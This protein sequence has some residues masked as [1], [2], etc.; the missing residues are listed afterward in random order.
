[1]LKAYFFLSR[2]DGMTLDKFVD[3]YEN[4]HAHLIA[5]NLPDPSD[6]RRNFLVWS[7]DELETLGSRPFDVLT[8]ITYESRAKFEDSMK[9]YAS[10]PFNEVVT[11][12][13]LRFINRERVRFAPVDEVIEGVPA[14][15]WRAAPAVPKGAKLMRLTRRPETQ[16][17][18]TFRSV[19]ESFE[20][21]LVQLLTAGCIDYR[22]NYIRSSDPFSFMTDE[23]GDELNSHRWDLVEEFCFADAAGAK[24]AAKALNAASIA[25]PLAGAFRTSAIECDQ[26]SST[27]TTS[28]PTK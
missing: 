18:D 28:A 5:D 23:F 25:E 27:A 16:D 17:P 1:M 19:Y 10:P 24:A 11:E 14:D 2:R 26:Y 15:E 8:A 6:S 3:Y 13:E 9:V 7:D 21:P 4:T 20:A 12:D 22:R